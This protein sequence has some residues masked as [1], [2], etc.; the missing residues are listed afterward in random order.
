M[1]GKNS[2]CREQ[3]QLLREQQQLSGENGNGREKT[4]MNGRRVVEPIGRRRHEET[5]GMDRRGSGT[6]I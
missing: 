4:T 3:Q 5:I 6:G 2:H 1:V